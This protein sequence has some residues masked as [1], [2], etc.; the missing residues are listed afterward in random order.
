MTNRLTK[1]T[2][3]QP[4]DGIVRWS[5]GSAGGYADGCADDPNRFPRPGIPPQLPAERSK[6]TRAPDNVKESKRISAENVCGLAENWTIK[7]QNVDLMSDPSCA[8]QSQQDFRQRM[9]AVADRWP[10]RERLVCVFI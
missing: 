6:A 2:G 10:V 5:G 1:Q 7:V 3:E 8:S 4:H 9:Y